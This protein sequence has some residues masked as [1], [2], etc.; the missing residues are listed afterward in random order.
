M[1]KAN[2]THYSQRTDFKG[3][4]FNSANLL[5]NHQSDLNTAAESGRDKSN[6][7]GRAGVSGSNSARE[8]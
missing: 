1:R 8:E 6:D 4:E 7:S 2:K 5:H 3:F